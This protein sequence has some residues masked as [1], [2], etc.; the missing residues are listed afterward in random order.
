MGVT[1]NIIKLN[2]LACNETAVVK[3][4]KDPFCIECF[5]QVDKIRNDSIFSEIG[6]PYHLIG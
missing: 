5:R 6:A 3:R 1:P 4:D 2:C